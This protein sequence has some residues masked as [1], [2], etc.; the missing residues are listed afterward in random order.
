MLL[1]DIYLIV[2]TLKHYI[3]MTYIQNYYIGNARIIDISYR[4][5]VDKLYI[6]ILV[7]KIIALC[8][9]AYYYT[10]CIAQGVCN[11]ILIV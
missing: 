5:V 4:G 2:F 3:D 1:F 6:V 8:K 10:R 7:N 11:F 9:E